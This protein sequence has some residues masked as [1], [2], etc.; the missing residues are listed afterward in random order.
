MS[1]NVLS[2]ARE[3]LYELF[4]CQYTMTSYAIRGGFIGYIFA[5]IFGK[6][7]KLISYK[8][9]IHHLLYYGAIIGAI[10]GFGK[11]LNKLMSNRNLLI[12]Y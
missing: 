9:N 5:K 12:R 6:D 2:F 8:F 1:S 10:Y 7:I 11:G 4:A 3:F